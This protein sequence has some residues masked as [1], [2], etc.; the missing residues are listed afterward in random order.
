MLNRTVLM[1]RLTAQP[2]LKYTPNNVAVCSVS[3][4]CERDIPGRDGIRE[5]DFIQIVFW[6]ATAE[7]VTRYFSKGQMISID[8]RLQMRKWTASDGTNRIT[9]EVVAD[10]AYF[11]GGRPGEGQN[12]AATA[13]NAQTA[14]AGPSRHTQSPAATDAPEGIHKGS[15]RQ[16]ELVDDRDF[17]Q[18]DIDDDDVPF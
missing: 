11:A 10:H 1:G 7:F 17:G 12:G 16:A 2:E 14:A 9:Y 4:A 3:I 6:R 18:L 15:G 13:A 5:T 8:G